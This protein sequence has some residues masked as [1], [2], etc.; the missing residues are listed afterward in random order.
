[1]IMNFKTEQSKY[2][3]QI[4]FNFFSVILIEIIASLLQS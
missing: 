4:D 2:I 1:M 3:E